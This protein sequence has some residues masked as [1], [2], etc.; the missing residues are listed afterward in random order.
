MAARLPSRGV[1]AGL[2]SRVLG[3]M[4]HSSGGSSGSGIGAISRGRLAYVAMLHAYGAPPARPA[5]ASGLHILVSM[6]PCDPRID[7]AASIVAR[8]VRSGQR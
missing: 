5:G 8:R 7:S 1:A 3:S 4:L 6:R 2:R